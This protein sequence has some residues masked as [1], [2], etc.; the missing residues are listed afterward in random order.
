MLD[1]GNSGTNAPGV[2]AVLHLIID[3]YWYGL[4]I[5]VLCDN[6]VILILLYPPN[7]EVVGGYIGFTLSVRPS[8]RLSV[9]P[10]VPPAVS[11]L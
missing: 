6:C 10:S 9:R 8:V 5:Y 11:A 7:N 3:S 1:C 4:K 2:T